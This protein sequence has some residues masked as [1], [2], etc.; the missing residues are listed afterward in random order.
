MWCLLCVKHAAYS[1]IKAYNITISRDNC[2]ALMA[3]PAKNIRTAGER[4]QREPGTHWVFS[5][6]YM[7]P[8]SPPEFLKM[9]SHHA[10]P[11]TQRRCM[12]AR[13]G[14]PVS[15]HYWDK[16]PQQPML[17]RLGEKPS[18]RSCVLQLVS[19][20]SMYCK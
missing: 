19:L 16:K 20:P 13:M 5:H 15:L 7:V 8:C 18:Y 12:C 4:E 14:S 1:H 6:Q 3:N 10:T 17:A 2:R 9:A 11:P